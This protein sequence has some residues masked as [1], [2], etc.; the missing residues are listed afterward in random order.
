[1]IFLTSE[2]ETINDQNTKS[3]IFKFCC[4]D[5]ILFFFTYFLEYIELENAH[6]QIKFLKMTIIFHD[7]L[8]S[9]NI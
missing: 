8:K 2:N 5:F 9:L 6:L 1:M 7:H 3:E 4:R